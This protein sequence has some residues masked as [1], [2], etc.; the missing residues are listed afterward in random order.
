MLEWESAE[1]VGV[2]SW[3]NIVTWTKSLPDDFLSTPLAVCLCPLHPTQGAFGEE[4]VAFDLDIC[5]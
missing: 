1:G 3:T 5:P 4:R 2:M